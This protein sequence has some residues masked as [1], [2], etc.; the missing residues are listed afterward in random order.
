MDAFEPW[1]R[2]LRAGGKGPVT[3]P[4][5]VRGQSW[6]CPF[7][8]DGDW[9]GAQLSGGVSVSPDAGQ[10]L[11]NFTVSAPEYDAELDA[12]FW[13]ISGPAGAALPA[14]PDLDGVTRLPCQ[15]DLTWP[16]DG[17]GAELLAGGTFPLLGAA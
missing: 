15:F 10:R 6:T 9:T 3:L 12:S 8:M 4:P 17:L 14:D 2:E 1:L 13:T 11:A 16:D 7:V 5:A